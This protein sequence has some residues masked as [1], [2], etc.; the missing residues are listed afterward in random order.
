[1]GDGLEL[2]CVCYAHPTRHPRLYIQF[3][4]PTPMYPH[5]WIPGYHDGRCAC[6]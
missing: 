6:N 4:K 1:M 3:N 2:K 5:T